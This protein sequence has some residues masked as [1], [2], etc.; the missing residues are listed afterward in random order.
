[1]RNTIVKYTMYIIHIIY[2]VYFVKKRNLRGDVLRFRILKAFREFE[3]MKFIFFL[4]IRKDNKK[5]QCY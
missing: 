1:M 4:K 5:K 3:F 2:Y